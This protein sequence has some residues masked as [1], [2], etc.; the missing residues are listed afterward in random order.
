MRLNWLCRQA[1][2]SRFLILFAFVLGRHTKDMWPSGFLPALRGE[3]REPTEPDCSCKHQKV[4]GQ[5][6]SEKLC[7]HT[8]KAGDHLARQ[9]P[10]CGAW[11]RVEG[12]FPSSQRLFVFWTCSKSHIWQQKGTKPAAHKHRHADRPG[13][14]RELGNMGREIE[15]DERRFSCSCLTAPT[16]LADPRS[17]ASSLPLSVERDERAASRCCT[18]EESSQTRADIAVSVACRQSDVL[19]N[20]CDMSRPAT[21]ASPRFCSVEW[22]DRR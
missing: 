1:P 22:P 9:A 3:S 2:H 19:C 16:S 7:H 17:Y 8:P 10:G 6:Q 11:A 13:T 20:C 5:K 15:D 4:N 21:E 14:V 12:L 18:S